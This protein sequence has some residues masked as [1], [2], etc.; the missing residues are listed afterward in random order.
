MALAA[1]GVPE[2]D[3]LDILIRDGIVLYRYVGVVWHLVAWKFLHA[4]MQVHRCMEALYIWTIIHNHMDR[5]PCC[6]SWWWRI[7]KLYTCWCPNPDLLRTDTSVSCHVHSCYLC[8]HCAAACSS[9]NNEGSND[10]SPPFCFIPG[11]ISGP[12]QRVRLEALRDKLGFLSMETDED[13][14]WLQIMLHDW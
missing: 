6:E 3:R 14:K 11:C 2:L 10:L 7:F 9:Q 8:W 5:W 12:R 4:H 1:A 13:K